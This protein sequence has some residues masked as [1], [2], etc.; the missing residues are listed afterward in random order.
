MRMIAAMGVAALALAGGA[1]APA[2]VAGGSAPVTFVEPDPQAPAAALPCYRRISDPARAGALARFLGNEAARWALDLYAR[3]RAVAVARGGGEGQPPAYVIAIVP[4]GDNAAVGF[5]LRTAAG[6][7]IHPRA[8]YVQLGPDAWRFSTTLLHETGHV[9]LAMLAGGREIPRREIAAIPHTLAAL[10]DRG[11]AFDEGFAISLETLIAQLSPAPDV[12]R[13]YR[14]DQFLFGPAAKMHAEYYWPSADLLTFAQTHARYAAVRDNA[15]AFAPA[16]KQPDYLRVQIETARD[17]AS[18]RDADQLLASEGF[19]ASFFFSVLV[20]G[21]RTPGA[22]TVRLR[23]NLVMTALAEMFAT[24]PLTAEE[25]FLPN[26]LATYKKVSPADWGDVLDV[27]LDLSHGV[28][29]DADAAALWRGHYLAALGLDVA[30]LDRERIDAARSRWH[31][32]AVADPK[33]LYARLGP[34]LRCE[35]A[36]RDVRLV[37]LNSDRPLSLDVNTAEE[38]VIRLVP[39]ITDGE[40]A[41]WRAQRALA[42]FRSAADF[43]ERCGLSAKVLSSLKF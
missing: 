1:A 5:R 15:F 42:P 33:A 7:E 27:F 11:T 10:T 20:R 25:P 6:I 26:F 23:Q 43:R 35:V 40:V 17:F 8:A 36:G 18:L 13:Q 39:G 19:Y 21:E 14:H 24:L 32:A 31:A 3:A 41:S 2:Q 16:F 28:S 12:R 30:H 22:D 37:G 29:V 34:Q 38:G 4:G 9:A